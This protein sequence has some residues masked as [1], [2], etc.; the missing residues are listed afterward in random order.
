MREK[1]KKIMQHRF[2]DR[3]T[4]PGAI[5]LTIWAFFL[6]QIVFGGIFGAS[7][8]I[9][10]PSI[11]DIV[12]HIG[13]ITGAFIALAIHKRWFYPE[14]EGDLTAG[15]NFGKWMLTGLGII[16]ALIVVDLIVTLVVG[17]HFAAPTVQ[18]VL[19]AATA[20]IGEEVVFRGIPA[21]Y[22]M[23]QYSR[24]AAD[25]D[26][27]SKIL[28]VVCLT[29]FIFSL[30]HG[31]N[32]LAGAAIS[33]TV[34][35]LISAFCLGTLLCALY[36]RSGSLWPPILVHFI[37]DVYAFMNA[38]LVNDQ[39]GIMES[40]IGPGEFA[41]AMIICAIQLALAC[42]LLRGAGPDIMKVWKRKWKGIE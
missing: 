42:L 8:A 26:P 20:G 4:I 18:S 12:V 36:L 10:Y 33:S 3:A 15:R 28:I 23:R 17:G 25:K 9:F 1:E 16:T 5:L 7:A 6:E 2:L 40:S 11:A 35:Q 34:L 24:G 27:R 13:M 21:S 29:S 32:I 14:F 39:T 41:I 19:L 37:N 38:D 31:G 22:M 30:A